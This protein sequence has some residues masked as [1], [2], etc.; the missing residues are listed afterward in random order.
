MPSSRGFDKAEADRRRAANLPGGSTNM[1]EGLYRG[2]DELRSVPAG[3]AVG[4]ARHRAVHRR[5]VEQRAG[6]LRRARRSRERSER[7]TSRRTA[8]IPT[9]RR[10]DNPHI[11][12]LYRHRDRRRQS[13]RYSLTTGDWN[14]TRRRCRRCR[15][16]RST[17]WHTHHRS[18]G[19]P[20][21]FPLQ[22]Q[23]AEGGRRSRRT[24]RA[25]CGT[26]TRQPDDIRPGV[27]HQQRR[28][29]PRRDHRQRGAQRQRRLPIRIYT[30]GMG[31]L[32]RYNLGTMPGEVRGHSQADGQRQDVAG[33]QPASARGQ[34]LL[35]A[36]GSRRGAGVSGLQN[37]I[38]RL[39]K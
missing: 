29:Q 33:L 6:Q 21:T 27:Q 8:P 24:R 7:G 28:A 13:R 37:Q 11:D 14:S 9:T 26:R 39:S 1:V 2:W 32:V 25:A 18:S 16:C 22:T 5:R 15:S 19:I 36:D 35:R 38:L 34:V 23:R 20:T 30:I 4:P 10:T 3:S 31:E 17:S 12:G